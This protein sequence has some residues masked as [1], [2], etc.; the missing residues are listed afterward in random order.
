MFGGKFLVPF[1]QGQRLRRLDKAA[2]AFR[3]F[4][5]IHSLLL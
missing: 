3:V 1:T 2:R 5:E 4:F